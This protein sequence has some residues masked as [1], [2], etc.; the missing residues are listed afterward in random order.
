M[1][2]SM[3]IPIPGETALITAALYSGTTGRLD[4]IDVVGTAALAAII[5]DNLGYL[6]GR[7]IGLHL[8]VRYG[9]YFGL[10]ERRLKVGQYA[11]LR[12]GDKI[13]FFGRFVAFL[14]AF[15][16][17]LAGANLMSWRRFLIM[18]GLGGI[19]WAALIGFG[20]YFLGE[21]IKRVAVSAGVALLIAALG[22]VMGSLLY[23]RR[24]ETELQQRA[25]A[26]L[27][28]PLLQERRGRRD[29]TRL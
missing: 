23:F 5:G 28:G 26:A 2:E 27:P 10:D 11:F 22:L 19:L 20:A 29:R 1:L 15:A 25:D 16:A 17:M 21:E 9:R 13:V 8:L 14:R 12:H 24:H 4:I 18:N 3:G 6:I 7:R